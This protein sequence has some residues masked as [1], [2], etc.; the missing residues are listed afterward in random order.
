MVAANLGASWHRFSVVFSATFVG[1]GERSEPHRSRY[2]LP[3]I[4]RPRNR[5]RCGSHDRAVLTSTLQ[6][7]ARLIE[8]S[9]LICAIEHLARTRLIF[10]FHSELLQVPVQRVP[11]YA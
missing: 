11:R 8:V 1:C 10:G 5:K 9:D 6:A 3:E 2:F 7:P 4:G